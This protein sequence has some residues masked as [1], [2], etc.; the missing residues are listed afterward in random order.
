[1]LRTISAWPDRFVLKTPFRISRGVKTAADVITVEIRQ[2]EAVGRGEAVPYPRYGESIEAALSAVGNAT[3]A[4]AGGADRDAILHLMPAGAARNAVDCALWD[5][6]AQLSGKTVWTLAG[7]VPPARLET[8]VTIGLD[9]PERMAAA[10][11]LLADVPLLKV[12]VDATAPE[13]QLRAVRE[14]APLPKLIVDPN[15]SWTM[16]EV[17]RLQQLLAEIRC[18]LL[19]QPL[20]ASAD[21]SLRGFRS[22]IPVCADESAHVAADIA[23]LADRYS[24]VNIKLDKTGGLTGALALLAEARAAGLGVMT[25]CMISSSLSIAAALVV[26]A[27]SDFAD[28]DGPLWLSEDRPGGVSEDRGWLLPPAQGFWGGA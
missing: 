27:Q 4:L 16:A 14:A 24:H 8:A 6:E 7:V 13:E 20:P 23:V 12:K 11:V 19:E 5:L 3:L 25:G 10:A 15:E 17:E 21:D 2:G 18:D 22:L 9:A 26:A 28:L 1:M